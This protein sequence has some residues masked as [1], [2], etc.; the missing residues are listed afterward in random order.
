M[1]LLKEDQ[2][3]DIRSTS[4]YLGLLSLILFLQMVFV[5]QY[6]TIS[7]LPISMIRVLVYFRI[8]N[9]VT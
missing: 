6:I 7:F 8:H 4:L 3:M 1:A 5:A 9:I 2:N